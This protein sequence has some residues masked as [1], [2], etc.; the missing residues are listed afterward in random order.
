M[1]LLAPLSKR[2]ALV[3][4]ILLAWPAPGV[5]V[6]PVPFLTNPPIGHTGGFGEPTCQACHTDAALNHPDAEL[7]IEG[8]PA[9]YT[10][11]G[12]YRITVSVE[13][14]GQGRNGFEASMR[15]AD[16]PPRGLQAG[17]L[18][19]T[20][21]RV[22]IRSDTLTGVEYASHTDIG[23]EPTAPERGEWVVEWT[24]PRGRDAVVL[25]VAGNSA[26]GDNSPFGDLIHTLERTTRGATP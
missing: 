10:P 8:V 23:A 16:G 7:A 15:Y 13:G 9:Q 14:T 19:A 22:L 12:V 17:H 20:D 11:G 26:N 3:G 24:A 1:V 25:H 21:R 4:A 2:V 5:S 6:D 18:S